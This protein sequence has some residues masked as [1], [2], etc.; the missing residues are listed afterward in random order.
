M[1]KL[2][3]GLGLVMTVIG[4][5]SCMAPANAYSGRGSDSYDDGGVT[6]EGT[7]CNCDFRPMPRPD[8]VGQSNDDGESTIDRPEP[9]R[10][11]RREGDARTWEVTQRKG[12]A[13]R[14][15]LE[16]EAARDKATREHNRARDQRNPGWRDK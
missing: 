2:L 12:R 1:N 11:K 16:R 5:L 4:L 15:S 3:I 7:P 9:T 13:E 8:W 10:A 6:I 14:K